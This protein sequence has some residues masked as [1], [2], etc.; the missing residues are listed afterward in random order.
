MTSATPSEASGSGIE[1]SVVLPCL[2]EATTVGTCINKAMAFIEEHGISG[3]V[4]VADN[5]SSDGSREIAHDLGARVVLV[6]EKGYGSALRG[7]IEAARGKYIIMGDS[8][9]SYDF[10]SL[11]P[12]L[13]KLREGYDLVM[14]NRFKGGIQPGAMP[15]LHRYLGNPVLSAVGRLFFHAPCGDFHCGL[16]GFSKDAVERLN[17]Q[18]TGMEFAS[19]IVAKASLYHMKIT[20]V[21]TTLSR[22]GRDRPPHIRSWRD[23]W[24]HLRFMLL[25]SPRWLFLYPGILLIFLGIIIGGLLL[26]GPTTIGGVVFDI[27]TLAYAAALVYTGFNAVWF[28]IFSRIYA[29]QAGLIP[30]EPRFLKTFGF[31]TLEVGLGIGSAIFLLGLIGAIASVLVWNRQDFGPLDPATLMRIV[32]PSILGLTIGSQILFSSFFLS[33]LRIER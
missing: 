29:L 24:R 19:E 23:G 17:L 20:E 27:H 26:P 28:A 9:D 8:D 12:F 15:P 7:G 18:T 6:E 1:L 21:P 2:N 16:R 13:A 31:I 32:V 11:M 10:T 14:G 25:F 5:G 3:E 33:I 30:R 4:I 22:D